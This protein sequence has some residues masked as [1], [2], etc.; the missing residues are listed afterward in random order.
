[1]RRILIYL[2]VNIIL[3][4]FFVFTGQILARSEFISMVSK[5]VQVIFGLLHLGVTV[6]IVY[7]TNK[8]L[9][10]HLDKKFKTDD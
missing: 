7:E 10:Q 4:G 2:F 3:I 1:M 8:R 6:M 9:K 5:M